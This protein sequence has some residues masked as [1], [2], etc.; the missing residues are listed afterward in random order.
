MQCNAPQYTATRK[1]H[2]VYV[3]AIA[4]GLPFK[5]CHDDVSSFPRGSCCVSV[6]VIECVREHVC[7]YV[8]TVCVLCVCAYARVFVCAHVCVCVGVVCAQ[9]QGMWR[10]IAK[11]V[12]TCFYERVVADTELFSPSGAAQLQV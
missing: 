12:D 3:P 4:A 7:L 11:E 10:K 5:I 8:C 2:T 1:P 9:R 6:N